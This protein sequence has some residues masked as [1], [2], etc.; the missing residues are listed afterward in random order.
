LVLQAAL[1]D[2]LTFDRFS[3][4]QDRLTVVVVGHNW[5]NWKKLRNEYVAAA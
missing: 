1:G 5:S 3:L 4:Q 2:G